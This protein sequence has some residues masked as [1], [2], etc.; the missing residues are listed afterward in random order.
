MV[1]GLFFSFSNLREI[2]AISPSCRSYVNLDR[3]WSKLTILLLY[4]FTYIFNTRILQFWSFYQKCKN[5]ISN[6]SK[7]LCQDLM[8]WERDEENAELICP[9][10]RSFIVVSNYNNSTKPYKARLQLVF[11]IIR[12]GGGGSGRFWWLP[13]FRLRYILVIPMNLITRT[14]GKP[15]VRAAATVSAPFLIYI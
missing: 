4:N 1:P 14:K 15:I 5:K 11:Y 12:G 3:L 6:K 10:Y 7:E 8:V 2:M 9:F 13:W